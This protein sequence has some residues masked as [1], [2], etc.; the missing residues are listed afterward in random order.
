MILYILISICLFFS[1]LNFIFIIFLSNSIFRLLISNSKSI[2]E[3]PLNI[4]TSG[5]VDLKPTVTYDPRFKN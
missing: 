1:I 4:T 5:L 2:E 3:K